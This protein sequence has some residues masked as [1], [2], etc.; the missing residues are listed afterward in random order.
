MLIQIGEQQDNELDPLGGLW[1]LTCDSVSQ[2]KTVT[3]RNNFLAPLTISQKRASGQ[4]VLVVGL[5][6]GKSMITGFL[7]CLC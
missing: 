1:T 3:Y 4:L 7:G 6:I 5:L 2:S